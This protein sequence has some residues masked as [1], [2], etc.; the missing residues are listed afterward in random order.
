M[1][2]DAFKQLKA[3]NNALMLENIRLMDTNMRLITEIKAHEVYVIN[4]A[5]TSVK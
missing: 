3:E 2:D 5:E 1:K 4:N